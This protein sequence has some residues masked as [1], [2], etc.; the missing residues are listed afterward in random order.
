MSD[1]M[2]A[3][4]S[5]RAAE[6][7]MWRLASQY[8]GRVG[9]RRSVKFEGLAADRPLIDC[10]GWVALLLTKGME[11]EN[12]AAGRLMFALDD[13]GALRTRSD[14]IIAEIETRTGFI[15]NGQEIT[16]ESLPRCATLGVELG[17]PAW[18]DNHQRAWHD[19]PAHL[20]CGNA[21]MSH[22]GYHGE[23][24]RG[25]RKGRDHV[26]RSVQLAAAGPLHA[27]L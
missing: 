24:G 5:F 18:A 14:R 2:P 3:S 1:A 20:A 22:G 9:Y 12:I 15:L 8:T 26:R 17:E 23:G 4:C 27:S 16:P 21:V 11:E 6:A 19:R 7:A 25:L 13:M 10:S